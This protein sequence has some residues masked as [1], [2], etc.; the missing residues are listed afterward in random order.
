ML[1]T[2]RI[3]QF[4]DYTMQGKMEEGTEAKRQFSRITFV[5]KAVYITR[6]TIK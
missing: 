1:L 3:S 5:R 4:I 6:V 2:G